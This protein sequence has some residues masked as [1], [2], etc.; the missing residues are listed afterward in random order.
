MGLIRAKIS[1]KN[2]KQIELREMEVEALID[3]GAL[4]LCIPEHISN[5]LKLQELYKRNVVTADGKDHVCSYVGPVE[6]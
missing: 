1:L 3:T 2:P 4:H 6:I 5:Q